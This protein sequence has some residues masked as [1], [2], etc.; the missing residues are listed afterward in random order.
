VGDIERKRDRKKER[1]KEMK[2]DKCYFL[3]IQ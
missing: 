3:D 1:R 2:K